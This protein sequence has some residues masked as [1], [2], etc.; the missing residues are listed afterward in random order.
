M[1]L[2]DKVNLIHVVLVLETVLISIVLDVWWMLPSFI[3]N[4]VNS[5]VLIGS[6][7]TIFSN[8]TF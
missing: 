3:C 1:F 7:I 4:Y 2:N 8:D 6:F 5:R